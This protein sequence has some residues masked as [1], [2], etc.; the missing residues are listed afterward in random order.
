MKLK[1]HDLVYKAERKEPYCP[2][3][4][5]VLAKAETYRID[6]QNPFDC[7]CKRCNISINRV[8]TKQ[9]FIKTTA[10]KDRLIKGLMK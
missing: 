1:E 7:G 4:E 2:S 9:W 6:P 3:C 8:L 10:Y 5:T